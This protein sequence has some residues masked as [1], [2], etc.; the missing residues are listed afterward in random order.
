[1]GRREKNFAFKIEISK[2]AEYE[3]KNICE[4]IEEE[5]G[6]PFTAIKVKDKLLSKLATIGLSPFAIKSLEGAHSINRNIRKGVC[7]SWIIIYE[8]L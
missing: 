8:I 4:Y 3:I 2:K 6:N 7:M 1:M 5:N